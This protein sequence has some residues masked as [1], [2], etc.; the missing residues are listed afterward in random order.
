[1]VTGGGLL[2]FFMRSERVIIV[3]DDKIRSV[4][5]GPG[6]RLRPALLAAA[7]LS[8]MLIAS[9]GWMATAFALRDSRDNIFQVDQGAQNLATQL[10]DSREQLSRVAGDLDRARDALDAALAEEAQSRARI[11][12]AMAVLTNAEKDGSKTPRQL[13]AAVR[14]EL[15]PLRIGPD[16]G[17]SHLRAAQESLQ[18]VTDVSQQAASRR[19]Q[20]AIAA[21]SLALEEAESL[22]GQAQ[23][24][25]TLATDGLARALAESQ[26]QAHRAQAEAET[27]W[28][29]RNEM[30]AQLASNE[31]RM[32]ELA[33]GQ[34]ALLTRLSDH[35]DL[36]IGAIEGELK[37]T[38]LNLDKVLRALD[39]PQRGMG[40]P[41]IG[42]SE[43]PAG[44]LPPSA[45]AALN[46]LESRL[47]RQ[48]R[49]RSLS[50]YLPLTPPVD[51]FYVSS[52]FGGRRDPFTNQ[53]A[54]HEGLDL[55][56]K[57]GS[58]VT[59]PA[60]GRVVAISYDEGYGH[61]VEVDHGLGIRTRYAHMKKIVVKEGEMLDPGRQVGTLG[62]SGRSSGPHL[63]YE[64]LLEGKP[65]DP[66]RFMERG[67]HVCEG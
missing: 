8:G 29:E 2:G 62:D 34:V 46:Q 31:Q 51:N 28:T 16:E 54:A 1:M 4:T 63:H 15:A 12:A 19:A 43:L 60:A 6:Q 24:T 56:A 18:L 38:G 33:A 13:L 52:G 26:A 58:P 37:N 39:Q 9:A 35:A 45:Q 40:G 65:V 42:L 50:N 53:W 20:A 44:G 41:L 21:L 22:P 64:V 48:A 66:L 55:V 10:A 7:A 49:L 59:L 14:N 36:R 61:M 47:D 23:P 32:T 17:S 57:E 30:A 25:L 5:I 3:D 67:R 11:D 27:A